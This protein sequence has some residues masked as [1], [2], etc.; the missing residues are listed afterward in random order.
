M[1]ADN[2]MNK[3]RLIVN[4]MMGTYCIGNIYKK[5]LRFE[6]EIGDFNCTF[7][8]TQFLFVGPWMKCYGRKS[9]GGSIQ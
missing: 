8:E 9:I 1:K 3:H 7:F 2:Y 4:G 5:L 6:F